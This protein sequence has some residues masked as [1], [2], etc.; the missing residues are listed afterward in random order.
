MNVS[1]AEFD[2]TVDTVRMEVTDIF[3]KLVSVRRLPMQ[4]GTLNTVVDFQNELA[5]GL[6]IGE[7][8]RHRR[9][10]AGR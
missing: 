9:V 4:D 7:P 6:Y 1:L 5:P 8:D 3:G 2:P 10:G